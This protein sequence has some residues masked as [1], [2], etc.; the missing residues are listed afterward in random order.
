[1]ATKELHVWRRMFLFKLGKEVAE[2]KMMIV[3]TWKWF[4]W[5]QYV[6][7]MIYKV[8]SGFDL[9]DKPCYTRI[10]KWWLISFLDDDHTQSTFR[11]DR[12]TSFHSLNLWERFK[13]QE[14]DFHMN[15]QI[16]DHVS[17]PEFYLLPDIKKNPLV[18]DFHWR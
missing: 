2:A 13:R 4:S 8:Q 10:W 5:K 7:W 3:E 1:M 12:K 6:L 14:N 15:C 17:L 11:I 9:E 18:K 16:F